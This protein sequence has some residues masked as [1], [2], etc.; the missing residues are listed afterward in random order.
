M[1]AFGGLILTN[2]GRALQA[3]AQA[4]AQLQFTKVRVGDGQLGSQSIPDLTN[5]INTIKTLDISKLKALTDGKAVIGCVLSNSGLTAGFYWRELGVFAQDPDLGEILYCYGNAGAQ[6][7]YIPADGGADLIEKKIDVITLVGSATSVT[8]TIEQSIIYAS[9]QDLEEHIDNSN[10]HITSTDRASWN[11]KETPDGAQAKA[12]AAYAAA[13]DYADTKETPAGAQAK[14]TAA[15]ASVQANLDTHKGDN[16]HVPHLGTTTNSSNAYTVTTTRTISDGQKFSVKFNVAASGPATLK[17]STDSVARL[18]KKPGGSDFVPKAGIYS[19]IRDG[20]NFQCLGEGGD[21]LAKLPNLI[22]NGSFEN[23]MDGWVDPLGWDSISATAKVGIKSLKGTSIHAGGF[24]YTA[25]KVPIIEGHTYYA[26][27]WVRVDAAAMSGTIAFIRIADMDAEIVAQGDDTLLTTTGKWELCSMTFEAPF[28][29]DVHVIAVLSNP[30]VT[31]DAY[32]DG[33]MLLDL[34]EGYP[35]GGMPIKEDIDLYIKN[36]TGNIL[37]EEGDF[38]NDSVNWE[39]WG[40]TQ[41][42]SNNQLESTGNGTA[43]NPQH[44]NALNVRRAPKPSLGDVYFLRAR[45]KTNS[46]NCTRL[47]VYLYSGA[48]G[49]GIV[50]DGSV[51]SPTPGTWYELGAKCTVTQAIIDNWDTTLSFKLAHWYADAAASNGAKSFFEKAMLTKLPPGDAALSVS[52]L[53]EKYPYTSDYP[54]WWDKE[55]ENTLSAGNNIFYKAGYSFSHSADPMNWHGLHY[56]RIKRSGVIRV[57][58]DAYKYMGGYNEGGNVALFLNNT[59]I[60]GT[61]RALETSAVTYIMDIFVKA[62]DVLSIRCMEGTHVTV[63][64]NNFCLKCAE[65]P[66]A[67][68]EY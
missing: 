61:E 5:M 44:T 43:I 6:A 25:T 4:G 16:S 18:L 39:V 52:Q 37:G 51:Y 66:M 13:K 56:V 1:S 67:L 47:G 28:T 49:V 35:V 11:A 30:L 65:N 12:D 3:K 60:A 22:Y 32:R 54:G 36:Y 29:G 8:A 10:V 14:A 59:L 55:F 46:Q 64:V 2:R 19:F 41:G 20:S 26:C 63:H 57:S 15:A 45:A 42:I 53:L 9:A 40:G 23:N 7:E 68:P 31:F 58:F 33:Y 50:G 17:I 24:T 48:A 62:N 34:T 21:V 27:C 38:T